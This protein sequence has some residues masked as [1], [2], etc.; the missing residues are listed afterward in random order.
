[1]PSCC[2]VFCIW[3]YSVS[4]KACHGE[5]K[6]ASQARQS[7]AKIHLPHQ[8][9]TV[10]CPTPGIVVAINSTVAIFWFA[11]VLK[12]IPAR[13]SRVLPCR[14][15]KLVLMETVSIMQSGS[16]AAWTG[17]I[18]VY[19][20]S[21]S[22]CRS[23]SS[24]VAIC[25]A[26]K[27]SGVVHLRGVDGVSLV[28]FERTGYGSGGGALSLRVDDQWLEAGP[29]SKRSGSLRTRRARLAETA[30]WFGEP[31]I[32]LACRPPCSATQR[33]THPLSLY[34]DTTP[35]HATPRHATAAAPA[36]PTAAVSAAARCMDRQ[37]GTSSSL[38]E[39]P[40]RPCNQAGSGSSIYIAA[41]LPLQCARSIRRK[42]QLTSRIVLPNDNPPYPATS[43]IPVQIRAL[44]PQSHP[45][46]PPP[47]PAAAAAPS[48]LSPVYV[49]SRSRTDAVRTHGQRHPG[50]SGASSSSFP[51]Q[52][53]QNDH[54]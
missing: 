23:L 51:Y 54:P 41:A 4:S 12:L 26:R 35:H 6:Y 20:P 7:W 14:M 37:Y 25:L 15:T 42:Q 29:A 45:N 16:S 32:I 46:T 40:T 36:A 19:S 48:Q 33:L 9:R 52:L 2:P 31:R 8:A 24:L 27:P 21:S 3:S 5:S 38:P 10:P 39:L 18:F 47:P 30:A 13:T 53:N 50:Q 22:N 17:N 11:N 34:D 43:S 49:R 1:M 28:R 44:S